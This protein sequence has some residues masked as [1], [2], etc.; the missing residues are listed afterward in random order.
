MSLRALIPAAFALGLAGPIAAADAGGRF[1]VDGAGRQSCARFS[2]AQEARGPALTMFAGWIDGYLTGFN[3][4]N[5]DTFDVTPWQT[6]D[7]LVLKM[8]RYCAEHPEERFID[9][10]NKLIVVLAP[11]RLTE[12]SPLTAVSANGLNVLLY[13]AQVDRIVEAL[14]AQ[15]FLEPG[16]ADGLDAAGARALRAFQADRSLPESGLPDQATLN[17]LFP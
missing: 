12:E 17:A 4:F 3:H 10:L 6:V 9:A 14:A 13:T 5:D 1:A 8:A 2:A 7:L 15:G 16:A 11:Q